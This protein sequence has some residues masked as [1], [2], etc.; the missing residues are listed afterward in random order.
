MHQ[1]NQIALITGAAKRVGSVIA[2][3]MAA[4]GWDIA[5][6]Y[7]KSKRE[8]SEVISQ[9]QSLGRRAIGIEADL[10]KPEEVALI[11][12]TCMQQL[13]LPNCLVNNAALFEFDEPK[14][15]DFTNFDAHMRINL[16]APMILSEQFYHAHLKQTN[17]KEPGVIIHLLD[18]KLDNLNPDFLSYTLSKAGL[19]AAMKMAALQ[20][21]PT[22]RVVGIAPGITMVS[23]DQTPQAFDQAHQMTPMRK[24][25]SPQD[26]AQ[27]ILYV[28]AARA[29]TGTTLQIDGGQ[30]LVGSSRDIMFLTK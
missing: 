2:L 4:A 5:I 27:G 11:L 17:V 30:H 18:Q 15:F 10:S 25:S 8:A 12:P 24:S 14:A 22:I 1:H 20:F 9:I 21:A 19:E 29:I 13:G 26:I 16:A 7:G 6:H 23:G 28:C 3:E